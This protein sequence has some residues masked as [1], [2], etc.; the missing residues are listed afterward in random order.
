MGTEKVLINVAAGQ[1][2]MMAHDKVEVF[3]VFCGLKLLSI[4]EDL[5]FITE[6]YHIVE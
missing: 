2:T 5:S 3:D 6:V 1:L 4:Y